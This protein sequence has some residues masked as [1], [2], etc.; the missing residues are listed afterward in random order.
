MS[1][2]DSLLLEYARHSCMY[3]RTLVLEARIES[4]HPYTSQECYVE[5]SDSGELG[6]KTPSYI[7]DPKNLIRP[8][9]EYLI[10]SNQTFSMYEVKQLWAL[11]DCVGKNKRLF[12]MRVDDIE[13]GPA[14]TK[15]LCDDWTTLPDTVLWF[16]GTLDTVALQLLLKNENA[17][18]RRA[19][20]TVLG[21]P[22]VPSS[23]PN[24]F[25]ELLQA[26]VRPSPDIEAAVKW[27]LKG[28]PAP[29]F[30]LHLRLRHNRSHEAP[31]AAAACILRTIQENQQIVRSVCLLIFYT[32]SMLIKLMEEHICSS[33]PL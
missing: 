6:S 2:N 17:A 16:K 4:K 24:T 31:A 26:F 32:L 5:M 29:D 23:R 21:N 18:M 1:T 15:S 30:S 28:G 7:G 33:K 20:A 8:F 9:G 25:G 19:A 3:A 27:A 14:R 11:H 10:Y 22:S 13:H 12:T